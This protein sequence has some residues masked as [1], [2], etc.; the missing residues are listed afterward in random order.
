MLEMNERE[1]PK[2]SASS[3]ARLYLESTHIENLLMSELSKRKT[4]ESI[5]GVTI[6]MHDSPMEN[7][8]FEIRRARLQK[9]M[10]DHHMTQVDVANRTGKT[11]SY[12]SLVLSAGKSFGEKTA[13]HFEKSLYMPPLW[14]D[15]GDDVGLS[16]VT[17]WDRPE[18]LPEGV[19]ALVP[20]VA[21]HLS[22]GNGIIA[23]EEGNLP[24]LAFRQDWLTRKNITSKSNLRTCAVRGDSMES[25]LQDGDTVLIDVGQKSIR[26]NDIYAIEHSGEIR[27]KR[28]SKTFNGGLIIS[29]D[30][31]R[32]KDEV[33]SPAD[34]ELLNIIGLM[35]WRGG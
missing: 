14:L 4:G 30:N 6:L 9:W 33:L 18:D 16:A 20:R 7:K 1:T 17:V 15:G 32:Y 24:P 28:L 19:Y 13:R 31:P 10:D 23:E 5:E 21:I 25:Y 12:V 22:A 27:I 2:C 35:V 34:S 11:R 26:D 3:V 29:S 8:T